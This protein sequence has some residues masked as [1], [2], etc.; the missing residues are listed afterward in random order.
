MPDHE[1]LRAPHVKRLREEIRK[2]MMEK[3]GVEQTPEIKVVVP[4]Q[5]N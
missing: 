4:P 2:S 5:K 3:R 1:S